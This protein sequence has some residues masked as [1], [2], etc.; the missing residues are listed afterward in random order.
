MQDY[1]DKKQVEAVLKDTQNEVRLFYFP[2]HAVKKITNEGIKGCIVFD[3]SSHSPGHPSLNDA[4]E[5]GPNLLP[6]ILAMLLGFRISKIAVTSDGSQAFLQLIL[7]DEDRDA[8]HYAQNGITWRFIAP[9]V[10]W[11]G[12]WWERLIGIVKQ[13]LRKVLGRALLDEENLSTVLIGI[14]A[15]LNSRPLVYEEESDD[16]SAALTPAHFL[17]GRKLTAILSRLEDTR[18]NKIYKQ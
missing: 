1:I 5:A 9:R 6:D 7:A 17:T 13:C 11:W 10:D 2:H 15:A 14:D 16:N 8:T 3:A 18:L 12:G 4:L